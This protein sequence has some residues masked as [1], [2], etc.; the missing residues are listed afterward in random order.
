MVIVNQYIVALV[1]VVCLVS[2]LSGC[3]QSEAELGDIVE[4][5]KN[6]EPVAVVATAGGIDIATVSSVLGNGSVDVFVYAGDSLVFNAS[7]S[8]DVDG[9]IVSFDWF[10]Y[11][12]SWL[13]GSVVS[14]V[15]DY[16]DRFS[17]SG[18][19]SQYSVVLEVKDCNG[20]SSF[21]EM[22]VGVVPKSFVFYLDSSGLVDEVPS[23]GFDAVA[24]RL[25]RFRSAPFLDF[26]VED[27][28][29]LPACFWSVSVG[30]SKPRFSVVTGIRVE[31][32]DS[33][34]VV[35][36]EGEQRF[37]FFDTKDTYDVMFS[38]V[39]DSM[40]EFDFLRVFVYGFSLRN[41]I[42]VLYGG[43]EA[44]RVVFDFS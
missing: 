31:L 37:S 38:G 44:A 10:F 26:F 33:S 28:V 6:I 27:A 43:S 29:V 35:I 11:D 19:V 15:F 25:G 3:I 30:V 24:A 1:V 32:F 12:G 42:Q 9:E 16:D 23:L 4:S 13:Q 5:S 34:G 17:F 40:V 22:I 36:G 20:S 18:S 8:Y 2:V 14:Y 39:F 41:S 21:L 7:E